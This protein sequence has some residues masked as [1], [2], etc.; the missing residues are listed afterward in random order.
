MKEKTIQY[1]DKHKIIAIARNID[2]EYMEATTYALLDG[3]ISMLEIP[4]NAKE[5][6]KNETTAEIIRM[7]TE[8]FKGDIMIGAGTVIDETKLNL[9]YEAGAKY[10]LTPNINPVI[11]K[12]INELGMVSIPGGLTPTEIETAAEAGADYV[13]L[14]P[15]ASMDKNYV[16]AVT[17]PLNHVK[18][19]G[20]GGIDE[21][22][23]K[24]YAKMGLCG[25]GVGG[26]LVNRKE[27]VAGE[28]TALT[29]KAARYVKL[30]NDVN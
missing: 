27:I 4:F 28:F 6:Y 21:T 9:A 5:I 12:K 15:I 11:I 25:F 20:V 16:K 10:I 26:C 29:K 19:H 24:E 3:G 22:N 14:F 2:K 1:I 23:I 18:L 30:V 17:A 8:K 7:L 13:K